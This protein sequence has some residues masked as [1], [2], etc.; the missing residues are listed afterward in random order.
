MLENH[1]VVNL[2][3]V[4]DTQQRAHLKKCLSMGR[5]IIDISHEEMGEMCGNMI[6]V[7]N[8]DDELCLILSERALKGLT[9]KHREI[10]EKSYK[11]VSS[12]IGT[13]EKIG[14]GSARCMVAELF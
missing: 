1:V 8:K 5:Q 13:I 4:T 2:D 10:L 7:K 12:D 6:Q 14:G 11:V 9:K 3:S